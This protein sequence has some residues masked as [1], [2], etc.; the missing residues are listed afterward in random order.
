MRT[1]S[2]AT[3]SHY[4]TMI[5]SFALVLC[6]L[7]WSES[8]QTQSYRSY[9]QPQGGFT[10]SSSL[11][12]HQPL[13]RTPSTLH[14]SS[15]EGV[16]PEENNNVPEETQD[17]HWTPQT[18][19]LAVPALIGMLADPLLSLMDTAYVGR[20]GPIELAALGA[21]TSIF[22][23]AFN[24]FRAT[25]AA[26]TSLVGTAKTDEEKREIV[27]TSL[28][29]G[30]VL[31]IVVMVTLQLSGAWCLGTMGVSRD[32]PLYKPGIAYL[33]TRLFAA[34]AVLAIVVSEGAFRGYGDTKIP[35]V[36]SLVA[37]LINLV[38][39]PILMFPLGLGVKGAAAATALAQLGAALTYLHFLRK[40]RM[41]PKRS[42][43]SVVN[44]TEIIKTIMGANAAMVLKQGSLLL[45][46]AYATA[47]ATR[48]GS[49][50]VA[51]HQVAL[52]CWLVSA[53]I[54]DGAAVSAQVLISRCIGQLE[55]MKSLVSYMF[56]FAGAQALVT[57]LLL[58][59]AA[60]FLPRMFT[61]DVAIL[62]HLHTLMPQV[63]WQ[64][65]LVSMTLVTES[66]A[67]GGNQ[68]KLLATG[69]TISTVIS[70]WQLR[71]A[72]DVATIWSRGIVSLFIGRLIT[73]LLGTFRTLR[74]QKQKENC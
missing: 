3:R 50:H 70:M 11:T 51:A 32:S 42:A 54:L 24:A 31:G 37:S 33:D 7:P 65:L 66:L 56:K 48:I 16:I 2:S 60:P 43:A 23:L 12:I 61:T 55:K 64:Q 71:Q 58:W 26:T 62:E 18:M 41:L 52:S 35:L 13:H 53:L 72:T 8:F 30:V 74:Q 73:A 38:L 67:V 68:F 63:A 25:T 46:W 44:R 29:L 5:V 21:C 4:G 19:E 22:H 1:K 28:S 49:A 59:G 17:Y 36:A 47:R 69:T 39:D 45:A 6:S 9:R 57:T 14:M 27:N 40:R 15:T 34:P 20:V 10:S